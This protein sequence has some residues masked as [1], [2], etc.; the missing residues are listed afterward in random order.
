MQVV[1]EKKDIVRV[2]NAVLGYDIEEDDL[3]IQS[4]PFQVKISNVQIDKLAAPREEPGAEDDE[5]SYEDMLNEPHVEDPE[6]RDPDATMTVEELLR[7]NDALA[8]AGPRHLGALET[9]EPPPITDAEL[10]ALR[11]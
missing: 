1:F 2:F 7:H 10:N 4:D 5:T 8:E 6:P 11:R 9:E 3:E